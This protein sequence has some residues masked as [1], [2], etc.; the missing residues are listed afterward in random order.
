MVSQT[1]RS[2]QR[3][4][5]K[6]SHGNHVPMVAYWPNQIKT[7]K[8]HGGLINFSDFYATFSE[9]LG[10]IIKQME[11]HDGNLKWKTS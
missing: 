9:I 8:S 2:G 1:K 5:G 6:I 10:L 7:S 4:Q 3:C 11:L